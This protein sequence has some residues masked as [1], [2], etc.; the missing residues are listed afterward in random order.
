MDRIAGYHSL[1]TSLPRLARS[2]VTPPIPT[3]HIYPS[4]RGATD[5]TLCGIGARDLSRRHD[6][7]SE[8]AYL[9]SMTMTTSIGRYGA[10][11]AVY[12]THPL[13]L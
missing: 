6:D 12:S 1:H 9:Y 5:D 3:Y 11:K 8:T 10:G 2:V 4:G 13:E 7:L